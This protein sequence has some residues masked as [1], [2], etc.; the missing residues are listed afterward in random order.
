[1][2]RL[3]YCFFMDFSGRTDRR[4]FLKAAGSIAALGT[5][6]AA[7]RGVSLILDPSGEVEG[8]APAR[9]AAK[10]LETALTERSIPVRRCGRMEPGGSGGLCFVAPDFRASLSRGLLTSSIAGVDSPVSLAI[11]AGK[12]NGA[13]V[14]LAAGR[15]VRG[16]VY[17][18]LELK[19]RVSH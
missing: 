13:D 2:R 15:D 8:A 6:D 16:L 7:P 9:W 19:D 4:E 1:P 10:E 12:F 18:L 17:A 11:A 3:R 14:L 5:A